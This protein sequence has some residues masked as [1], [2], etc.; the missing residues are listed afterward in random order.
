[1][2]LPIFQ[3]AD[4]KKHPLMHTYRNVWGL[5][6]NIELTI[7]IGLKVKRVEYP[8]PDGFVIDEILG[9]FKS[10]LGWNMAGTCAI[11]YP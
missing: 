9:G 8:E 7:R 4:W 2:A 6:Q 5:V 3:P 1:M 10:G 11:G